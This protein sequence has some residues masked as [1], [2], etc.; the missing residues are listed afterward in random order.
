MSKEKK[1]NW[2]CNPCS[3]KG[4]NEDDDFHTPPLMNSPP[5]IFQSPQSSTPQNFVTT[6]EKVHLN[7]PTENTFSMLSSDEEHEAMNEQEN[8]NCVLQRSCQ[9]LTSPTPMK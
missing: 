3:L 1:A 7:I 6:R 4:K 2:K 9:N 5:S 8:D